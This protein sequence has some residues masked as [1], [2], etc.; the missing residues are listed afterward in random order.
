MIYPPLQ[1]EQSFPPITRTTLALYAGA[2]GD[3]N[4]VHIDVD[5]A[6]A[7]GFEDVFAHGM[8]VMAYMARAITGAVPPHR[9]RSFTTRFVAI[10]HLGDALTCS[11]NGNEP[12]EEDGELRIALDLQMKN[13]HG[14]VK[15]IGR[16]I[17]AFAPI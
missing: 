12:F 10:T 17:C 8:L 6:H 4:P 1:I 14:E 3:I 5:A 7:A 13:Q 15:L 2:S 11:G 9:L 16:A